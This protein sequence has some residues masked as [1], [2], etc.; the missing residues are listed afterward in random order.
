M[1]DQ[2]PV[3]PSR[4]QSGAACAMSHGFATVPRARYEPPRLTCLGD[5]RDVTLGG[6]VGRGDSGGPTRQSRVGGP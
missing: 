3:A 4:R 2:A 5:L 1:S 6:S